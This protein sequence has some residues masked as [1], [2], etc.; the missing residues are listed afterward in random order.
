VQRVLIFG[1]DVQI[2]GCEGAAIVIQMKI[3]AFN[4]DLVAVAVAMHLKS[5]GTEFP[6]RHQLGVAILEYSR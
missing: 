1:I 6:V 3:L 5:D 4:L 2:A